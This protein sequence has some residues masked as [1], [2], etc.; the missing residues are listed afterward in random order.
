MLFLIKTHRGY[1]ELL[2]F[3]L[4]PSWGTQGWAYEVATHYCCPVPYL[5]PVGLSLLADKGNGTE[6]AG[7]P[8]Q[9]LSHEGPCV[10]VTLADPYADLHSQ[11]K[12]LFIID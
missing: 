4:K 2:F 10:C 9:R 1:L 3:F 12:H 8:A 7:Q 5:S 6:D 11:E